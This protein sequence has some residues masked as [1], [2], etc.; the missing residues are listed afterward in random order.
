MPVVTSVPGVIL[1]EDASLA[2]SVSAGATAVPLFVARFKPLVA[3]RN[4]L[5]CFAVNSGL[6]K[7]ANNQAFGQSRI[8][9]NIDN[10]DIKKA[11]EKPGI[12]FYCLFSSSPSL[13]ASR[14]RA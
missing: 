5:D 11:R 1:E 14:C 13:A 2:M 10:Q 8:V 6:S 9:C 7:M 4:F 3:R 12:S